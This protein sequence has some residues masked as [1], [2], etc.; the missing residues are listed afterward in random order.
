MA[1]LAAW[2][3]W[4]EAPTT[5]FANVYL[6]LRA[7]RRGRARRSPRRR[8]ESGE[9]SPWLRTGSWVTTWRGPSTEAKAAGVK[10]RD[11]SITQWR[12]GRFGVGRRNCVGVAASG[13]NGRS[14]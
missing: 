12:I 6:G 10:G 8:A 4:F 11:R 14:V 3:I 1:L 9:S 2:A 7:A 13:L 5:K